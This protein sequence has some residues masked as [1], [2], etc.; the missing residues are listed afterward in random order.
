[1]GTILEWE[2]D[3][4]EI[5]RKGSVATVPQSSSW[6]SCLQP[7]NLG[8]WQSLQQTFYGISAKTCLGETKPAPTPRKLSLPSTYSHGV[9]RLSSGGTVD[10]AGPPSLRLLIRLLLQ[11]SL[12]VSDGILNPAM[13]HHTGWLIAFHTEVCCIGKRGDEVTKLQWCPEF[14][15]SV[16]KVA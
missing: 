14:V 8:T 16:W 4:R 7:L 5:R 9:W 10:R 1:M 13:G 12:P 11:P 15:H 6:P 2:H 3:V